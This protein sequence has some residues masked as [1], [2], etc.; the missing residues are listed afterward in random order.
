V[1]YRT[2]IEGIG[3]GKEHPMSKYSFVT[4]WL[5]ASVPVDPRVKRHVCDSYHAYAGVLVFPPTRM[6]LVPGQ[7]Q[8]ILSVALM[9]FLL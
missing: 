8:R 2:P 6:L 4:L 3:T 5:W 9:V 7:I 1:E